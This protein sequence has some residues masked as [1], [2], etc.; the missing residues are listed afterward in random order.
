MLEIHKLV[1]DLCPGFL[2]YFMGDHLDEDTKVTAVEVTRYEVSA[3][4]RYYIEQLYESNNWSVDFTLAAELRMTPYGKQRI[5]HF[6]EAGM[7]SVKEINEIAK[8]VFTDPLLY[9][10]RWDDWEESGCD[11]NNTDSPP[12]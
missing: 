10:Y 8:E 1:P 7:I 2:T 12:G 9:E 5:A 6:L 11:S 4:V 3:I